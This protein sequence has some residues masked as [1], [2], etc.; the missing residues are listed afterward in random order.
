MVNGELSIERLV[1]E[2]SIVVLLGVGGVGKTSIAAASAITAAR[3]GRRCCV[4]TI[5]PARRLADALGL[6]GGEVEPVEIAGDW[7][8]SLHAAVLDTQSTF[9]RLVRSYAR[10]PDQAETILANSVYRGLAGELGGTQDYMAAERLLE[11]VSSG[12]Y[13]LV[14]VDTP[15]AHEAIDF[16]RG[17]GR[18]TGFLD[19]RILRALLLPGRSPLRA[20][21]V[22]GRVLLRTIGRVAGSEVVADTVEFFREFEGMEAGFRER[23][24]EVEGLLGSDHTGYVL[25]VAGRS[26]ETGEA[27]RLASELGALGRRVDLL[28][29]NR[30]LG[31]DLDLDLPDPVPRPLVDLLANLVE[32]RGLEEGE[33]SIVS[34]L[35]VALGAVPIQRVRALEGDVHD[36]AGL[37]RLADALG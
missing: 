12:R 1:H 32:L 11:L 8:G 35:A 23:A 4:L 3:A 26:S 16:L 29:A 36:L 5:D 30:D 6:T 34:R 37:A 17:P 31:L 22:A 15:P 18:L 14:V 2:R 27:Q 25:V 7:P 10:D 28:V 13:D 9:D 21:S 24:S 20:L 33:R 19:N